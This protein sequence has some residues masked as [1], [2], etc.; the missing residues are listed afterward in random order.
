MFRAQQQIFHMRI[1]QAAPSGANKGRIW[2]WT[3]ETT[4]AMTKSGFYTQTSIG[5]FWNNLQVS[6]ENSHFFIQWINA[7][8]F[9]DLGSR[10]FSV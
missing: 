2:A 8:I 1:W 9:A 6:C 3:T 10:E 5:I 7:H 4:S